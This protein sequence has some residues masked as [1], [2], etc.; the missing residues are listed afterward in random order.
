M[1]KKTNKN[2]EFIKTTLSKK[3]LQRKY[4]K[5]SILKSIIILFKEIKYLKNIKSLEKIT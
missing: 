1:R 4:P 2:K 5:L 3:K